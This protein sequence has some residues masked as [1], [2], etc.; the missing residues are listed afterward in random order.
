MINSF[1][2]GYRERPEKKQYG[3]IL[4]D[5]SKIF[6]GIGFDLIRLKKILDNGILSE[7]AAV[8]RGVDITRNYGGYNLNDSISVGESPVIHGTHTFGAFKNYIANGISFVIDGVPAY[9]AKKGSERDSGYID[10]AYVSH[11]ISREKIV[12]IMV[13]EEILDLP[14][15]KIP[16]GLAKMGYSYIDNR[17]RKIIQDLAQECNFADDVSELEDIMRQKAELEESNLEYLEKDGQRRKIFTQME[18]FMQGYISK[19]YSKKLNIP[20]P[21]LRN[22]LFHQIPQEMSLY[23]SDGFPITIEK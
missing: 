10:E 1:E 16:V 6:H 19:A 14:L 2:G 17:C 18:E 23:N 5:R 12:G 11:S 22:T 15:S 4:E 8:D 20:N 21:T 9:K 7:K 13:P 3:E